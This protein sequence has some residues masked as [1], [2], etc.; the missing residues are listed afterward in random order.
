[1]VQINNYVDFRTYYQDMKTIDE[2]L[3]KL[4]HAIDNI[5]KNIVE[6]LNAVN[7]PSKKKVIE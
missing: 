1:M 4:E 7:K 3:T 2:R 6:L 5:T